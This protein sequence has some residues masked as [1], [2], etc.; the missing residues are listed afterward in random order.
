MLRWRVRI[1]DHVACRE[2]TLMYFSF[3]VWNWSKPAVSRISSWRAMGQSVVFL[4]RNKTH[5]IV[6]AI[7]LARAF[8]DFWQKCQSP[9]LRAGDRDVPSIVGS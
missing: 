6:C 3:S 4:P 7:D 9:D 2:F 5:G 8:V 1:L